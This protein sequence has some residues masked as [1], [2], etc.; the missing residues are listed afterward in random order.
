MCLYAASVVLVGF[1]GLKVFYET[2]EETLTPTLSVGNLHSLLL[3]VTD[4]S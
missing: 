2:D 4:S 1:I 3:D